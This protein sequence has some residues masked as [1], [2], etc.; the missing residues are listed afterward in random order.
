MHPA[1]PRWN[2]AIKTKME[3]LARKKFR[4]SFL[5]LFKPPS[6]RALANNQLV[7]VKADRFVPA[8]LSVAT[9]R[10][11]IGISADL[12][13]PRRC[14]RLLMPRPTSASNSVFMT[15]P[16]AYEDFV[17]TRSLP[18][19]LELRRTHK[20]PSFASHYLSPRTNT[21][22]THHSHMPLHATSDPAIPIARDRSLLA[23]WS[24]ISPRRMRFR[25]SSGILI[26]S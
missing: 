5:E 14:S 23:I 1:T 15:S 19:V 9:R 12:H 16:Q 22:A 26:G 3:V 10:S 25:R 13:H 8:R 17:S 11:N 4:G 24:G 2:A 6:L 18:A 20:S 7:G 21:S